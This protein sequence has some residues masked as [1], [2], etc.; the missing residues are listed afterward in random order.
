MKLYVGNLSFD[1]TENDLQE[2]FEQ[3]GKVVEVSL[4]TDR[5]TARSR[6]FAFVTM[7]SAAEGEAAIKALEGKDFQGRNLTVNEARPREDRS[8]G[9]GG[10]GRGGRSVGGGGGGGG[11]GRSSGSRR[12]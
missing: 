5:A 10:G 3:A 6:G 11:G 7:G 8:S 12:Y 1:T 9:G 4:V 2:L